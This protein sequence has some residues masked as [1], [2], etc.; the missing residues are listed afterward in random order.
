[1]FREE[2]GLRVFQN[3]VLRKVLDSKTKITVGDQ[4][5]LHTAELMICTYGQTLG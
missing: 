2:Y 3:K 1:M 4:R 5:I